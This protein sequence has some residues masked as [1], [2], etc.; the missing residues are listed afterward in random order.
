MLGFWAWEALQ[1]DLFCNDKIGRSV[2]PLCERND[3]VHLRVK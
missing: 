1:S 3:S 2:I